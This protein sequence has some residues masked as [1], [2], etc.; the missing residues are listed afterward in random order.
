MTVETLINK[1]ECLGDGETKEFALPFKI[2][3]DYHVKAIIKKEGYPQEQFTA[4]EIEGVGQDSGCRAITYEP[5]E[6]GTKIIFY[7]ELPIVQEDNYRENDG[8]L[9]ETLEKGTD[10]AVMIL[11]QINEKTSRSLTLGMFDTESDPD[12]ILPKI[13]DAEANSILQ[14]NKAKK[15]ADEAEESNQ[16]AKEQA[17]ISA[18]AA[19]EAKGIVRLPLY[20]EQW[21]PISRARFGMIPLFTVNGFLL[22]NADKVCPQGWA[23][24]LDFK[25]SGEVALTYT[26]QQYNSDVSDFGF[27]GGFVIDETNKTIRFPYYNDNFIRTYNGGR[28]EQRDQLQGHWHN[29]NLRQDSTGGQPY[30][31]RF[32][33]DGLTVGQSETSG[34][35]ERILAY[36]AD[37]TPGVA[38]DL[39]ADMN[40]GTPRIGT[41]TRP[42]SVGRY[43]FF[44]FYN[45]VQPAS[46]L[47]QAT[48]LAQLNSKVDVGQVKTLAG[49]R[50]WESPEYNIYTAQPITITHNLNLDKTAR[51]T[52]V[53]VCKQAIEGYSVGDEIIGPFDLY[54]NNNS[55]TAALIPKANTATQILGNQYALFVSTKSGGSYMNAAYIQTPYF[56]YKLRI[57]Y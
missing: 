49:N 9:A 50:F 18:S 55:E 36:A 8:F 38:L 29:V 7:R 32:G 21:L 53:I 57:W 14:A 28:V 4:F 43:P 22:E 56:K 39:L 47:Q 51:Y 52:P 25:N 3:R 46:A 42:K 19:N 24:F 16:S 35:D 26:Q 6:K 5:L 34:A 54:A 11:Q 27:C 2:Y 33:N 15:S 23:D 41:Y 40:N 37:R 13:F 1:I 10:R 20:T 30:D 44:I 12:K 17:E 31:S 45:D 48:F